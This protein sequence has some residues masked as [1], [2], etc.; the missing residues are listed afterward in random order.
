MANE[1][2]NEFGVL[3]DGCTYKDLMAVC[4][5]GDSEGNTA[6]SEEHDEL[7]FAMVAGR[8]IETD[9]NGH[10]FIQFGDMSRGEFPPPS[11]EFDDIKARLEYLL[12]EVEVSWGFVQVWR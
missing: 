7:E 9:I 3:I 5:L 2:S 4:E 1:I 6:S 11:P 12:A 8:C 10:P